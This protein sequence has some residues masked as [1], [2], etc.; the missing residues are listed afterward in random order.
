MGMHSDRTDD[1]LAASFGYSLE[2]SVIQG[3]DV[4]VEPFT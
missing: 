4:T 2:E 3:A 1:E